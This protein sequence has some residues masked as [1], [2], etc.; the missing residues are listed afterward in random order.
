MKLR[1][2]SFLLSG[3]LLAATLLTSLG[4]S[5]PEPYQEPQGQSSDQGPT[6]EPLQPSP[7]VI[8]AWEKSGAWVSPAVMGVRTF[9]FQQFPTGK[10]NALPPP[11]VPFELHLNHT[12]VTDAGLKELAS[13]TK[14]RTLGLERTQITNAGLK[15][16]A[17]LKQLQMLWLADTQVTD[18]GVDEWQKTLPKVRIYH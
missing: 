12:Q 18:A 4:Y 14:L 6:D 17:R 7:E 9:I 2:R 13:L 1:R 5:E 15:E 8:V 10:F 16:L 11:A 3:S